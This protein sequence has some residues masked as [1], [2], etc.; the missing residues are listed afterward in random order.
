MMPCTAVAAAR[1]HRFGSRMLLDFATSCGKPG[2]G[3][4]ETAEEDWICTC[5]ESRMLRRLRL[6]GLIERQAKSRRFRLRKNGQRIAHACC[7]IH[8]R[9]L[10]SAPAAFFEGNMQ[11]RLLHEIRSVEEETGKH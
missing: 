8:G 3:S 9:T 6:R 1:H 2:S 11:A 5:L 7:R 4:P 10:T